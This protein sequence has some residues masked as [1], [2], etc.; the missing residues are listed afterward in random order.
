[1][2]LLALA[3]CGCAATAVRPPTPAATVTV[4][5]LEREPAP[6]NEHYYLLIFGSQSEPL[7]PKYTHSWATAVRAVDNGP[8]QPPLVEAATISWMPAT[9]DIHP[10]RFRVE[11]GVDLDL[12]TTIR[13]MRKNG[14]RISLWG[15]YEIRPGLYRKLV[16]QKEFMDSGQVG[17]QCIDTVGEG[18][19][20]TGCDCIHAI[21]DCDARYDRQ[22]YP[23]S[24]FGD[25]ASEHMVR[26]VME[27]GGVI[28]R[29][30][31]HDWLLGPLGIADCPVERRTYDPSA[32]GPFRKR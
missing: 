32:G 31:N 19:R 4:E 30:A 5:D 23:L 8:G 14:E 11:P 22:E 18:R 24:R 10:L 2:V 27:R 26:Q 17:Y 1:M 25:R 13:E 29:C 6:P 20:G 7:R 12:C 9:L 15:P 3:P 28:D 21:T 16:M